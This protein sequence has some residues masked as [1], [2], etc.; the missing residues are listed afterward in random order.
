M[1]MNALS[2]TEPPSPQKNASKN[3]NDMDRAQD[4]DFKLASMKQT[5]QL[6]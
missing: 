5:K 4:N 6:F 2:L 1:R 3:D